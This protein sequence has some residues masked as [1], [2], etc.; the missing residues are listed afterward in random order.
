MEWS[1]HIKT[2]LRTLPERPGVYHH[3]DKDG[4]ILYIGKAKNLKKRVGSYFQKNHESARLSMLVRKVADIKTIVT[5]TEFDALLL[6]NT[7][8]KKHQPRYNINLKDG[9]TYPWICIK[10]ERFP[11]IFATR[12]RIEDGSEY[13]GPYASVKMMYTMLDIIKEVFTLRTCQLPMEAAAIES[14]KYRACLEFHIKRCLAPCEGLQDEASYLADVT[15]ARLLLRGDLRSTRERLFGQMMAH[16]ASQE[17][18]AAQFVKE[19]LDRL[20]L[21]QSKSTVLNPALGSVDVFSL[22]SDA[23]YGYVNMLHIRD[24]AVIQS[25]TLELRKRLEESDAELMAMGMAELRE[26]FPSQAKLVLV[27]LEPEVVPP[28]IEVLMPQR[29]D[30]RAAVELSERNARAYRVERLKNVQLVDP[31][32]HS[33]R[34]MRQMQKDL[35]LPSEPRR[36]ECFDNSNTQGT[37]PV[38]ACVVF[39]DGKPAKSEYRHFNVKTVEGPDDFATMKEALT[40]RYTRVL[41]EGLP[42]PQLVLIDGGKGQLSSAVEVFDELGLRGRV[43]L[44]GIAKRLEELYFPDDSVPLYLDKR[45]ETLKVLQ[46]A[47]NEAHRF[48]IT[49][50]RARRSKSG[51]SSVL[52][53]IPG[54][55][56]ATV[57]ILLD[58]F[59]SVAG[60]RKS[61]PEALVAAVGAKKAES[62]RLALGL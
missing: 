32:R 33:D 7:L 8:I 31:E 59:K 57:Q 25:F 5:E 41:I 19:R 17:F 30:K 45:S 34:I 18:E 38:S 40:R 15:G 29:G 11:R 50:H 10:K 52:D 58:T 9:K 43:A 37:N 36:I 54:V 2:L 48:G 12:R 53:G 16:S 21:Y 47:R 62:L 4:V 42:L 39:I 28:N 51:L 23:E 46:Q 27:S 44:I 24:G 55:G 26:R 22:L 61:K 6:E 1:E 35:R 49:H 14:G 13:F 3:I 60:I 20:D 56:P